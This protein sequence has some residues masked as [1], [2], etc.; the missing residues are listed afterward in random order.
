M[1]QKIL[2]LLTLLLLLT[3]FPARA[4][5]AR[6]TIGN[7]TR[8]QRH[9]VVELS[10]D[11]VAALV[12][13]AV[14]A[15]NIIVKDAAGVEI[16]CQLTR[17]GQLLIF[18]AVRPLGEA[19]FTIRPG[20]AQKPKSSVFVRQYPWR[21][22]DLVIENDCSGY[23][24]YG[25]SLQRKGERGFGIDVWLKN[26]SEMIIDSLY[27]MQRRGISFHLNHGLG[28]DCYN[29]GPSLGCGAPALME[30]DSL[31]FPWCYERYEILE[32]GPLRLCVR[33]DFPPSAKGRYG[34]VVEHRMV[35][36]DRG[37]DF[38]HLTVWY[39]GLQAPATVAAGTVIHEADTRSLHLGRNYVSYADPTGN[40][41]QQNCQIYV[42]VLFPEGIGRTKRLMYKQPENGIAGH[43]VGIWRNVA[44]GQKLSYW[45]GSAWSEY[46]V[47]SQ[48]EWELRIRNFLAGKKQPLAVKYE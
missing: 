37:S 15:E 19:T 26:T 46:R 21:L 5:E 17:S 13:T 43:A 11:S 24:F 34:T 8:L 47:R 7:P 41:G 23:R 33:L 20:R 6:I 9:E 39:D 2:F 36:M 16:P 27:R 28:M 10:A 14:T 30:G 38:T 45:F 25:P 32:D 3:A 18:A 31:L 22:D 42:A 29:V 12:G 44:D 48:A 4:Q 35:V 1:K 40:P